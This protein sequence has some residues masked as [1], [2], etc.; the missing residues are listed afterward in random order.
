M[1]E[2]YREDERVADYYRRIVDRV[3]SV[4]GVTAAGIVN[5]LPFTGIAQTR[6]V[7][8][9][10]RQGSYDSD[11]RSATPGYFEAIGIPL[12]Q[13]RLFQDSDRAQSPAV[14]L[15]DDRMAR[16]V[17]GSESA[18]GKRFRRYL[19]GLPQQDPWTVIVGVVGHI[20]ND[21]LEQDPRPQ[22]Y[23]PEAQHTQDRGALVVRTTSLPEIYAK[24]VVDQ[25]Q[26]ED[27]DQPVYDIRT[28]QQW[29]ARTMQERTLLTGVVAL[30]GWASLL[31]SSI[32]LYGVVSYSAN[33]RFR[34]FGIRMA[35]GAGAGQ[36]RALVLRH[37][38][39][40]SLWGCLIGLILAWPAA[41]ALNS[42]LFGVS[43]GDVISWLLA[44]AL[45]FLIALLSCLG[46][47]GRA[48]KTDPAVALR[49][50]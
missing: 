9:E 6:G 21:N 37:A 26:R 32:G 10:G 19:P 38:G 23:W 42:L 4:P 46:P 12:K 25:I 20:L 28:M 7:E 13:G 33:L 1:R 35:L 47:G 41:L 3:K 44:P 48:A 29:V 45:L 30:F 22:V 36:V 27:S 2:K 31:L 49:A 16:K 24:A 15:I 50:E 14:G 40:L 34:E 18:I 8:F 43:S 39:N 17:F 11:W 5:R